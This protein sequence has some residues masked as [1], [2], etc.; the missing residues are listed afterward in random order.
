MGKIV[1]KSAKGAAIGGIAGLVLPGIG[2]IAGASIGAVI[3][4]LVGQDSP[5]KEHINACNTFANLHFGLFLQKI[6]F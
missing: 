3:G 4:A 6:I 5:I 1:E 2:T